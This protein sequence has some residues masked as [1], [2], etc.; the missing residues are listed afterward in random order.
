MA[1][2]VLKNTTTPAAAAAAPAAATPGLQQQ[3]ENRQAE[4]AGKINNLYDMQLNNQKH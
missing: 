2:E 1:D 3:V 4:S